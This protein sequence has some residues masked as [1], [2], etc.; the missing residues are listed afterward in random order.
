MKEDKK[1]QQ[2]EKCTRALGDDKEIE[3]KKLERQLFSEKNSKCSLFDEL[4][5]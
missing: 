5:R 3:K 2:S 4:Q 1:D